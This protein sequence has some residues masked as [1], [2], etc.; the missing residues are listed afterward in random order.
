MI[1]IQPSVGTGRIHGTNYP[2]EDL[3]AF[4][5]CR[6]G[7]TA[8][9]HQTRRLDT[10]TAHEENLR[11]IFAMTISQRGQLAIIQTHQNPRM[12]DNSPCNPTTEKINPRLN[13]NTTTG[14]TR[15]PGLSSVYSFSIVPDEPPAPAARVEL[16]RALRSDS[17]WSAAA[18][19]RKA[20]RGPPGGVGEAGRLM[21]EAD[22]EAPGPE[23]GDL[24]SGP[25]SAPEVRGD[26]GRGEAWIS[27]C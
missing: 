23:P 27:G 13:T 25:D 20:A 3:D 22:P 9:Q 15:K 17:L 24:D 12:F 5:N 4:T 1:P 2:A 14:S 6:Q 16:G 19:R 21:D 26:A 8:I 7:C 10:I 18:R 11:V